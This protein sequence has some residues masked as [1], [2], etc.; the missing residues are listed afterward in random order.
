MKFLLLLNMGHPILFDCINFLF[1]NGS[2]AK[3]KMYNGMDVVIMNGSTKALHY[4]H[5]KII[6]LL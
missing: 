6:A 3:K 1:K 4:S 2:S 5:R